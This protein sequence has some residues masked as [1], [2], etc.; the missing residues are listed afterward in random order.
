MEFGKMKKQEDRWRSKKGV[1]KLRTEK[2]KKS[3]E[4]II[5]DKDVSIKEK[6]EWR[7]LKRIK[8][9]I[10]DNQVGQGKKM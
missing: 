4:S 2:K 6:R 7:R 8:R 9:N 1:R 3:K 5:K 10:K